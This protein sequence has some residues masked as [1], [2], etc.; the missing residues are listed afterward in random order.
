MIAGFGRGQEKQ[1]DTSDLRALVENQQKQ[2]EELQRK[3]EQLN[4]QLNSVVQISQY[5]GGPHSCSCLTDIGF[6]MT[7]G[8]PVQARLPRAA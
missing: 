1:A 7:R 8:L 6:S 4:Q 2:L 3:I 5:Q